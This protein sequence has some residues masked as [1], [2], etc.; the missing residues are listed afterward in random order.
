MK[1]VAGK[2]CFS[3]SE[4]FVRTMKV[5]SENFVLMDYAIKC[6]ETDLFRILTYTLHLLDLISDFTKLILK[7]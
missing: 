2:L 6:L 1:I 7:F 3:T 4:F 5:L